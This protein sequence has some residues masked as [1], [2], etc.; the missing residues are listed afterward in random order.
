MELAQ[1]LHAA[2]LSPV[3]ATMITAITRHHFKSWPGLTPQIISKNLP[4]PIATVQGHLHQERQNLQSIRSAKI[5]NYKHGRHIKSLQLTK[6]QEKTAQSLEGVLQAEL[7]DDSF[8]VSPTPNTET[9]DASYMVINRNDLAVAYT[10]LTRRFPCK[11]S[12]GNDYIFVAY[13]FDENC[14]IA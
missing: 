8:P 5:K 13:H 2:C 7:S 6:S 14:I 10:D 11:S 9:N 4:I 12:R 1:Y 3:K